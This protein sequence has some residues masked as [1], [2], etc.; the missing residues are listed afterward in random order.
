M[1]SLWAEDVP[2]LPLYFRVNVYT[3][4]PTLANY[5]FSAYTLYPSWNAYQIG[6]T[7]K[8]AAEIDVQK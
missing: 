2:S 5:T 7:G 8:G 6:W 1:Q 3:K 4:V